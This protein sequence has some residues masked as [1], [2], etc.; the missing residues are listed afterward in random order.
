MADSGG[1]WL[2]MMNQT[3]LCMMLDV[4]LETTAFLYH[5]VGISLIRERPFIRPIDIMA[6][7]Q[8]PDWAGFSLSLWLAAFL[9]RRPRRARRIPLDMRTLSNHMKRDIGLLDGND[10][11]GP[12]N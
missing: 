1:S 2:F 10:P 6:H 3:T 12:H 7:L 11:R 9:G 5:F 8:L 4:R